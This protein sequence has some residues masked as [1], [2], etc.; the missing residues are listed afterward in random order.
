[1]HVYVGIGLAPDWQISDP[2]KTGTTASGSVKN[3]PRWK[4]DGMLPLTG[5]NDVPNRPLKACDGTWCGLSPHFKPL[6]QAS[7]T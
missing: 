2:N 7:Q 5:C 1:M 4:V 6:N 3:L